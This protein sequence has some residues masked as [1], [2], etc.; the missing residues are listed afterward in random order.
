MD[1]YI[2]IDEIYKKQLTGFTDIKNKINGE[3][4][5]DFK[6]KINLVRAG[7]HTR[8]KTIDIPHPLFRHQW[9]GQEKREKEK[10]SGD[11]PGSRAA[12]K[13]HGVSLI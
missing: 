13:S 6:N 12:G 1:K 8:G 10:R 7:R 3:S 11:Q 2:K 4:K 5:N 9:P